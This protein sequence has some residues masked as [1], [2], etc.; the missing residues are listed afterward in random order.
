MV[1]V[2][3]YCHLSLESKTTYTV[4]IVLRT[5][6]DVLAGRCKSIGGGV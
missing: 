4:Y 3:G 2:R 5:S 6:G 1:V